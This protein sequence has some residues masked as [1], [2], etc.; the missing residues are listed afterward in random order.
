[1]ARACYL[2]KRTATP[3]SQ[4]AIAETC[5]EPETRACLAEQALRARSYLALLRLSSF[6]RN[7]LS[8]M[9]MT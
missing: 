1:M 8:Q 7:T 6:A 5:I 9:A 4:S 2:A 3:A